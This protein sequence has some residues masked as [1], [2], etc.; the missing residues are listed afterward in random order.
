M[1]WVDWL[2]DLLIEP[3]RGRYNDSAMGGFINESGSWT[4]N[5]GKK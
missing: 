2:V 1:S 5:N 3:K 4:M